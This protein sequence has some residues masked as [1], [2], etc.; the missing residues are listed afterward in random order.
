MRTAA[1]SV[2][3]QVIRLLLGMLVL[4]M[5]VAGAGA[6]GVMSLSEDV[7]VLVD[8]LRPAA[9]S[10]IA[11]RNDMAAAQSS[12][13]SWALTGDRQFRQRYHRAVAEAAV[14]QAR[15]RA[16]VG[17][18]AQVAEA[19]DQQAASV[20]EWTSFAGGLLRRGPGTV[21][22]AY[23]FDGQ[24]AFDRFVARNDTVSFVLN[25][26]I[27]ERGEDARDQARWVIG[28]VALVSLL[29]LVVTGL[30]GRG[31]VRRVGEPLRRMERAVDRL[32]AGDLDARVSTEGPREIRGVAA[33]L[34]SLAEENQRS[35]EL[36]ERVVSE[37]RQLDRAKDDFVS[38]VSH[39]LRTPLTSI[40]GYIELFEDDFD[41]LTPA[42][43]SMLD[44]VKRNV[45]RLRNL[46]EDLLTLS[47]V[48]SDTFR[49]SFDALDLSHL[50][51]DV[52]HDVSA[53]AARAGV[54][55]HESGPGRPVPVS[56]DA[57]QLSRAVL[58]LVTNAIKFSL[59]GGQVLV[60][61]TEEDGTAV[62]SV[63]DHG[64]GIP[65]EELA[66]LGTRFFRATNAV[67]AEISGTGLGLK[68]VR[69]IA[70]KHGGRLELESEVGRGTTARLAV[71][72]LVR[73]KLSG[74]GITEG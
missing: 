63:V 69:T 57:E 8:D 70:D 21:P 17:E 37:R 62:I 9:Y 50:T 23:F 4:V 59:P 38:T 12:A 28:F 33:A 32:A 58:N 36:E 13:K 44:V 73:N 16:L 56:G 54:R 14:E 3:A 18:D 20:D 51:S 48:E 39:E 35:R 31:V 29:G 26:G 22:R 10:N 55:V 65:A 7:D 11:L 25:S 47:M 49:T 61:L 15:L 42:Q 45:R 64:I 66:T 72:V 6:V 68:I 53:I 34:N 24:V 71:P 40:S 27:E 43:H 30:L 5:V 2:R 60:R 1:D 19:L 41:A 74:G 67:E 52:V 46:I